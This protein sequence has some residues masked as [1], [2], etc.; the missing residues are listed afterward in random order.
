MIVG[1]II[2]LLYTPLVLFITSGQLDW[3]M[4]WVY[5]AVSIILLISSRVLMARKHPDLVAERASYR[6]AKDVKEWDKKLNP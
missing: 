1:V 3:W 6:D 2:F 5:S 4:A